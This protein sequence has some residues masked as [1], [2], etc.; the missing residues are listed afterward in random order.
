MTPEKRPTLVR[1]ADLN[2]GER[3][4]FFALLAERTKGATRDGKPFY[5]CRFR[6][7]RRMATVMMW[8]DSDHFNA[9]DRQWLA[10]QFFK[11][12][13]ILTQH[14]RYGPQIEIIK[15]RPIEERDHADGFDPND[16]VERSR[17]DSELTFAELCKQVEVGIVD[18]PLR[19]LVLGLLTT[20][21]EKL[22]ILP[23]SLRNYYPFTGGWVEHTLNVVKNCVW[24]VERYR[25]HYP[26]LKP[27]LNKDLL[28]AGAALHEIGRATELTPASDPLSAADATIDGRLMGHLFLGRD[29][30]RDAAKAQGDVHPELMRLLEHLLASYLTLPEW[31][32]PRLPQIPEVLLLHHADDLDVQAA[33]RSAYEKNLLR[34]RKLMNAKHLIEQR[35][36]SGKGSFAKRK[37]DTT[38]TPDAVYRAYRD[39]AD[40]KQILIQKAD[41]TKGNL[42]SATEALRSLLANEKFVTLLRAEKLDNLPKNLATRIRNPET[43]AS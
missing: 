33:L 42:M 28:L 19:K 18:E 21:A 10:G 38:T 31:G 7:Q 14:E 12:H 37:R 26:N 27:T 5:T 6:D 9:C 39:D 13:G 35:L 24:L 34:G 22:K 4:T 36:K 40:R 29:L 11:I 17:F 32:S 25:E 41:A 30:V 20:H 8:A 1:L 43:T 16:F 15:I 2:P 3:G 23:A